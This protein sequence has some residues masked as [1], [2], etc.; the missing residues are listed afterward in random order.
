MSVIC[1]FFGHRHVSDTI[2]PLLYKEIERHIIEKN[3]DTFYIGG[4]GDFDNMA[5]DVLKEMKEK[6]PHISIS[7]ILA[8]IPTGPD[9]RIKTHYDT[10]YPEGLEFAPKK[11]AITYRN[12]WVAETSDYMIAYVA[13][14]SGG[15]YEALKHAKRKNKIT[16]NLAEEK[17]QSID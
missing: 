14:S 6:Y 2:R 13:L 12:R 1:S 8:Y 4:Y 9:L 16:I 17:F 7:L 3:V 10:L 15:A 11:Y 5:S